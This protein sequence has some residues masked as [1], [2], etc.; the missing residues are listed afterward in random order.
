M[1]AT[2]KKRHS[3]TDIAQAF[4]HYYTSLC[5]L[6]LEQK[7]QITPGQGTDIIREYLHQNGFKPLNKQQADSI[8]VPLTLDEFKLVLKQMKSGKSPGPKVFSL[9]YYR[10]FNEILAAPFLK[11]FNSL[12]N[13]N[14]DHSKLL[15]AHISVI[16]KP[17]KDPTQVQNY[18]PISLLNVDVKIFAKILANR[19]LTFI[20]SLID[21]DQVGFVPGREARDNT[22]KAINIYHILSSTPQTGLLLSLDAEK[23]FDRLAW[24]YLEAVLVVPQPGSASMAPC[25]MPS[26]SVTEPAKVVPYPLSYLS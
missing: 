26:P 2:G 25:L 11:T 22:L 1:D 12:D 23:A 7:P 17:G 24:D 21:L 10:T 16:L 14:S 18:R 6:P 13:T 9:A 15:E 19:L 8:D 20:P 5:N 4:T 3:N